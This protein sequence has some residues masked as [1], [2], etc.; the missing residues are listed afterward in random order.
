MQVQPANRIQLI[1]GHKRPEFKIWPGHHFATLDPVEENDFKL[2][3]DL[4]LKDALPD[5]RFKNH[6][7]GLLRLLC[8]SSCTTV[9]LCDSLNRPIRALV[10]PGIRHSWLSTIRS[11]C[12]SRVLSLDQANLS[13]LPQ[14]RKRRALFDWHS[15]QS[16]PV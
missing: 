1:I 14:Y 3:Q 11:I 6:C 9:M 2:E 13:Q 16:L 8:P 5:E 15:L 7:G 4:D 10:N 12:A